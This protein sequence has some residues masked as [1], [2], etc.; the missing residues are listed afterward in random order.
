MKKRLPVLFV[1]LLVLLLSACIGEKTSEPVLSP[2]PT[3]EAAIILL[4][5]PVPT[6]AP[7]P[8]PTP[9][10]TPEPTPSLPEPPDIDITEFQYVLAN[11]FNPIGWQYAPEYGSVEGQGI[12]NRI[13]DQA[14]AFLYAAREAGFNAWYS[15]AYRNNEYLY[16]SFMSYFNNVAGGDPIKAAN[17]QLAVCLDEHQTGLAVDFT[18]DI[19]KSVYYNYQDFS[20]Y[21]SYMKDTDLYRW[22]VEHCADYGFILRY[23]EGKEEFYGTPCRHPAHFRYVGEEAAHYIMD[24]D[25]CLEE[26]LLLYEGNT[27]YL[28]VP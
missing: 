18:D 28:P 27:V 13:V 4:D 21:D 20:D 16:N 9:E 11:S 19:N 10:P 24:N 22:A 6:S 1:L 14:V 25:L 2:T 26:F 12:E 3:T 15:S 8:T 7:T 5:T 17:G 23:P